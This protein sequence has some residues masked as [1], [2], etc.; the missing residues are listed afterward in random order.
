MPKCRALTDPTRQTAARLEEL[1]AED[2]AQSTVELA[3]QLSVTPGRVHQLLARLG[4]V[5]Q[6]RKTRQDNDLRN[7]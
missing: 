3:R 1:V 6:W 2:P 5:K 7:T 4:Y